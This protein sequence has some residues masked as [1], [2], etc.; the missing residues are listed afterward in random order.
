MPLS[1]AHIEARAGRLTASAIGALMGDDQD[2]VTALWRELIGDPAFA[3]DDLSDI[4]PVQLGV[5]TEAL[6]LSWYTRKTGHELTPHPRELPNVKGFVV[7][8]DVDWAAATLDGWDSVIG[9]P[10]ECKHVGGNEP[11][12]KVIARYMPQFHWQMLVTGVTTLRASIIEA[13]R[14]PVIEVIDLDTAYLAELWHRACAFMVHVETLTPPGPLPAVA[15]PIRAAKTYDMRGNNEWADHAAT[16][17]ETWQARQKA[18]KAE[19]GLKTLVPNDAGRV[20]GYGVEITRDR[21]ARLSLRP[22]KDAA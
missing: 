16:F 12:A 18:D 1:Q 13:A 7:H 10:V 3:R 19:R 6:N 14:V 22:M 21:A 2:K 9:C 8:R 5:A 20:H 4:W 11:L 17:I 15:A